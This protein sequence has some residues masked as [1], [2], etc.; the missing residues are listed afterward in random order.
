ML[1]TKSKFIMI[2]LLCIGLLC[3]VYYVMLKPLP[4]KI[5]LSPVTDTHVTYLEQ[6]GWHIKK[7]TAEVIY[8]PYDSPRFQQLKENGLDLTAYIHQPIKVTTY[9]LE[10]R[11]IQEDEYGN[12]RM[13]IYE[14][15]NHIIGAIGS[16]ENW[17]PG[18]LR[19]DRK[20]DLIAENRLDY[21]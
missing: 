9:L 17:V 15:D 21:K 14:Y 18:I 4:I 20:Q 12:I 16:L 3:L 7:K 11:E 10:E 5:M 1:R 8:E 13:S 19:V 6:Y 2:Y